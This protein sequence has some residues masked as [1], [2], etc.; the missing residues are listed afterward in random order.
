MARCYKLPEPDEFLTKYFVNDFYEKYERRKILNNWWKEDKKFTKRSRGRYAI[1]N[2]RE[3]YM[4]VM[5][6]FCRL[7]G[8][9]DCSQFSEAWLPLA[10]YVAMWGRKFNWGGFISKQLSLNIAKHNL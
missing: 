2:M 7:Y 3:P 5:I 1:S 6:L 8:E 4:Y 10:Y 9:K